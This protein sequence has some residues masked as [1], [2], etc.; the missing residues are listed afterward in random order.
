MVLQNKYKQAA[1][2]K[3]KP[4][5]KG[6]RTAPPARLQIPDP[7]EPA[8]PG[9]SDDDQPTFSRRALGTNAERYREEETTEELED[10]V[11]IAAGQ[12]P[13][14]ALSTTDEADE[15][16][17]IIQHSLWPKR[18]PL[19]WPNS[20]RSNSPRNHYSTYLP[21]TTT[22]S[23]PASTIY[24]TNLVVP[25]LRIPAPFVHNPPPRL[26][27]RQQRKNLSRR[28]CNESRC[29]RTRNAKLRLRVRSALRS[30]GT[31]TDPLSQ[32]SRND[33]IGILPPRKIPHSTRRSTW[34]T[35]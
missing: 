17:C 30:A 14:L 22:T 4:G 9:D 6:P 10:E 28:Y 18:K 27:P 2:S 16:S 23:T 34:T 13:L 25:L 35:F 24:S 3:H 19:N 7:D 11:E 31:R 21:S 12:F 26:H 33:S 32:R 5:H 15:S 1:S 8:Q 29:K 20:E